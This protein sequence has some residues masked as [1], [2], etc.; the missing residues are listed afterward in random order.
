MPPA[1][2]VVEVGLTEYRFELG[3]SLPAGRVVLR[4]TNTGSEPHRP[5]LLRLDEDFPPIQEEVRNDEPRT[6][7]PYAGVPTRVPGSTGTFAVDLVEGTRYALVCFVAAPDGEGHANK[8]MTWES[9]AGNGPMAQGP[10]PSTVA[11]TPTTG[12]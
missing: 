7:L 12:G 8:G 3:P 11:E 6:V 9:R 4:F 10:G 5:A 1:P 2:P